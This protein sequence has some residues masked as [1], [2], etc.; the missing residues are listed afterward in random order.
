MKNITFNEE[1]NLF[2]E[3]W[4]K[5]TVAMRTQESACTRKHD[6]VHV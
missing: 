5:E 6:P 1:I 4:G 2:L 3:K